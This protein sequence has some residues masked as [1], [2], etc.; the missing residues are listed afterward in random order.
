MLLATNN[1]KNNQSDEQEIE[2]EE[3]ARLKILQAR[4]RQ[5]RQVLKAAE[6]TRQ[7]R[8]QNGYVPEIDAA[9]GKPVKSDGQVAAAV[10][11]FVLAAGAVALRIGGRA[12][13]VSAVGLDFLSSDD[14]PEL[15]ANLDL[16]LQTAETADPTTKVFLF[17]AAWTAV[18][19]LCFD[20]GGIVLALSAG[21]LF[22][23]VIQGAL[24]S[25]AAATLGSCAAYALAQLDTP[26]RQ[27]ALQLLE[28]SPSLIRGVEKVIARDGLKAVLT[29]RL[30]PILP[31]PIGLYNYVYGVIGVPLWQFAGGIFLGSIKPY[32]LD[33]YLGYFGKEVLRGSQ[34]DPLQDFLLLGA[35]GVS[36]LIGVF[37]SQLASETWETVLEEVEAEKQQRAQAGE[38]DDDKEGEDDDDGIVRNIMG[39]EVPEFLV[40]FQLAL[41]Q[42]DERIGALID[43]E[44]VA[45]VWNCTATSDLP[46]ERDP[47][48][49]PHSLEV[50]RAHQGIDLGAELCDG[51]VLS[52]LLFGA[53]L[54]YADPLFDPDAERDDDDDDV[55]LRSN[56]VARI[57]A[58]GEDDT[59]RQELLSQLSSV[60]VET[61]KRLAELNERIRQEGK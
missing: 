5:I 8:L 60:K 50:T 21:I 48:R 14:N 19:V 59:A 57:S 43:E 39:V 7:F 55:V 37:A 46:L 9:T 53:F 4:R 47:A 45:K 6:A 12:A 2:E 11:A 18:K 25:A 10:T 1:N 34:G 23:G 32:L 42:A 52:P 26:V 41:R 58:T 13:L 24:A 54:K 44:C 16:I 56:S 15:K 61:R 29:L 22:G 49:Q 38:D 33:S 17:A 31:I 36:V 35:L 27:K 51:L 20:A 28:D 40:G 3:E 30:A